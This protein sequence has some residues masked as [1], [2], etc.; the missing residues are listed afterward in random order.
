LHRGK[1]TFIARIHICGALQAEGFGFVLYLEDPNHN[2]K[3]KGALQNSFCNTLFMKCGRR[4]YSLHP[5]TPNAAPAIC[6][7]GLVQTNSGGFD[8]QAA[9]GCFEFRRYLLIFEKAS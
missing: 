9:S 8:P 5:A 7:P 3:K 6:P 4:N 1:D 2:Q